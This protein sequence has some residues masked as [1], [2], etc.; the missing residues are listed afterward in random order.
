MLK[1]YNWEIFLSEKLKEEYVEKKTDSDIIDIADN[2]I[3]GLVDIG[4]K[5]FD[6]LPFILQSLD[7]DNLP[8]KKNN[9]TFYLY[10]HGIRAIYFL[11]KA[12]YLTGNKIYADLGMEILVSYADYLFFNTDKK[13]LM[14]DNDH[15]LSERIENIVYFYAV[16]KKKEYRCYNLLVEKY[17]DYSIKKLFNPKIYQ[18]NH[19]HGMIADKACLIGIYFLNRDD[20]HEWLNKVLQR[21]KKQVQYAFGESGVHQENSLDYHITMLTLFNFVLAL[22]QK[23]DPPWAS[24]LAPYYENS[25]SYLVYAMK[26]NGGRPLLGDSKGLMGDKIPNVATFGHPM[27]NYVDSLGT[28]GTPP[29]IL[30]KNFP[31]DVF[32]REHFRADDFV[33]STYLSLR[34]GY[35]TRIHKHHDDMSICLYSKGEDI[36][37]DAGMCGFMPRDAS[38]DY[39]ESIPAHT[40]VGIKGMSYSIASGNRQKFSILKR[41]RC[42]EY[43]YVLSHSHV[44]PEVSI[45][46]HVYFFRYENI[47]LIRDEIFSVQQHEFVQYFHLGPNMLPESNS[48]TDVIKLFFLKN[49][50]RVLINQLLSVDTINLLYGDKTQP[51]SFIST[52]FATKKPTFTLEYIKKGK[53]INFLTAINILDKDQEEHNFILKKKILKIL[54]NENEIVI[55]MRNIVPLK[56]NKPYIDIVGNTL[57]IKTHGKNNFAVYIFDCDSFKIMKSSYFEGGQS[58]SFALTE[59]VH[60][61]IM[62]YNKNN[63]N[64][65]RYGIIADCIK[66]EK[67]T[68]K[69]YDIPHEPIINKHKV[70]YDG[71]SITADVNIKYDFPYNV[72]WYV[73]KDGA[74]SYTEINQ[75]SSFVYSP[76][77]P[78]EYV[79]MCSIRDKYFGEFFFAQFDPVLI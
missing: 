36:F 41:E 58:I 9:N 15:A 34:C 21:F 11:G 54:R 17:I 40:T 66:N 33:N 56:F 16:L 10:L 57:H 44:Y 67:W 45:Y 29:D 37:I 23:I 42:K 27:L 1:E 22:L 60:F 52:G 72:M 64:E 18:Q 8:V 2:W 24:L 30:F 63:N 75:S 61:V 70:S 35:T 73:Y 20:M 38:K 47:V 3:H 31:Y 74:S 79:L 13:N 68:I 53:H 25:I 43:D 65:F 48:D 49:D 5:V 19:N 55:P 62:Y 46:R 14:V 7:W 26:P 28:K 71:K 59:F 4:Y 78:G 39:M 69:K 50:C 12:F 32:F 6:K 77:D 51:N 76:Y